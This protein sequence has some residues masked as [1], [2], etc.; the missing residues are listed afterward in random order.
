MDIAILQDFVALA[1][2]ETFLK[3]A[4]VLSISQPTLSRHIKSLEAELGVTLF[5]R[6][7]R[8]L[9]LSEYGEVLLPYAKQIIELKNQLSGELQLK[10]QN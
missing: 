8:S 4:D 10:R 7:T 9:K 3:A 2:S 1:E 6:T 5:E